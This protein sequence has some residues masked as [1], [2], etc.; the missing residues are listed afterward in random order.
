MVVL[1]LPQEWAWQAVLLVT[2]L[3][4]MSC[5]SDANMLDTMLKNGW[6]GGSERRAEE[7]S[8]TVSAQN[9]LWCH[10]NH[11]CPDKS[12]NNTCMTNGYCFTMVEEEEGGVAV[13]TSGCLAMG[14]S[15]FQCRV[16][17][18]WLCVCVCVCVRLCVYIP[19]WMKTST[20]RCM[21][22]LL[23][24]PLLSLYELSLTHFSY[25]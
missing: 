18:L 1:W 6:K 8:S 7:G 14:G 4:S 16:S 15:E 11:H 17:Q 20:C 2:G 22:V 13:L 19:L 10:C 3:A 21:C 5:G 25:L 9:M 24:E 12:V 23:H